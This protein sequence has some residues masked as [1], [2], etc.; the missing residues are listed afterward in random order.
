MYPNSGL[1]RELEKERAHRA[2]H[3]AA[4]FAQSTSRGGAQVLR[5]VQAAFLW[6]LLG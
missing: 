2:K 5:V 1:D 6:L 3:N 4:A